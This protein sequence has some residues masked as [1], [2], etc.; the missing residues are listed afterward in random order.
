MGEQTWTI[1]RICEELGNP[2]VAQ[3]FLSEINR[4]PGPTFLTVFAKWQKIAETTL[5]AASQ[6]REL[7]P[8]DER[9]EQLPGTWIDATDRVHT[10]ADASRGAA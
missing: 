9:G 10:E 2:T 8:Y 5:N 1:E 4:A 6:A 3:R 7:A